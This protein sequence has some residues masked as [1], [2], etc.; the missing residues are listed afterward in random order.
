MPAQDHWY[1]QP[2]PW[3]TADGCDRRANSRKEPLLCGIHHGYRRE[4][5][6]FDTIRE[7]ARNGTQ[8]NTCSAEDCT[9]PTLTR[10]L[11][12]LHYS[13]SRT[14][15]KWPLCEH[16]QC[17]TRTPVGLCVTHRPPVERN[18]LREVEC[19][20]DGC[21]TVFRTLSKTVCPH[22]RTAL[23]KKGLSLEQFKFLLGVDRCQACGYPKRLVI[24]H[25]HGHHESDSQM[26]PD[27]I[28]GR[29]CSHCNSALGLLSDS[30]ERIEALAKYLRD[31]PAGSAV[32]R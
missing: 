19:E 12:G 18:P 3:C 29:L 9:R 6:G 10:G 15:H 22:H 4:G 20:I 24:D 30:L 11:C 8:D 7:K 27:C 32:T 25:L 26:C 5:R 13:R 31:N 17:L 23:R 2:N 21:S 1:T 14:V 28:R 16:P